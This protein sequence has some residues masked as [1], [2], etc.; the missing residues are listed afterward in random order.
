MDLLALLLVAGSLGLD[1]FAA[2]IAIGLSGIDR[3]ARF[4]VVFAFGL[5]EAAM[6]T[7]GLLIGRQLAHSL[8]S[9]A[10]I[11]GGLLLIAVGAQVTVAA[12]RSRGGSAPAFAGAGMGR[13]LILAAALSIDNL[14]VGF[15][16]GAYRAPVALSVALIVVV[17]VG[18]SLVGLELGVRLGSRV[19][20]RSGLIGGIVLIGVG[21]AILTELL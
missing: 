12:A 18:L 1:N 14:V 6:P 16:L 9:A 4:R 5:F 13:L 8:G 19:G 21:A 11:V 2:S 3:L 20:H 15:A 7:A 17:S 10:H